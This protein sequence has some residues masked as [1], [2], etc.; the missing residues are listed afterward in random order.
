MIKEIEA[1]TLLSH[2]RHPDA[3]FGVKYNMN[4]YRGC[5]HHCIYC[6]SRSECY[7]IE[8]FDGELLVKANAIDLLRQELARKRVK[9]TIGT[10]AMQDPYTP[11]EALLN[12]TG[13]ALEVIAEWRYPVHII[14]KSDL[15]LKDLDTLRRINEVH[16]SV[17]FTVTTADDALGKKVEPGA[18]LVSDRFR[19]A[20]A[21]A[22]EGIQVGLTLMPVLPLIEDNE[23]NIAEIMARAHENGVS[24]VAPAFGMTMRRGQREYFYRQLDRLFPG[25]R[26]RYERRYGDSYSCP[27]DNAACLWQVFNELRERYGM[28]TDVRRFRPERVTQ[29]SLF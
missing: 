25:L 11:S 21:L 15:I 12:M 19:A 16:A 29:L 17:C 4:L 22:Q 18:P 26:P 8:D 28:A 14:T 13:Q 23:E 1:K 2:V 10:G 5:E 9:G 7:Q 3:W 24:F 6:D 27:S 20:R